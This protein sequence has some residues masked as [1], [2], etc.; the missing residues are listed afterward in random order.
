MPKRVMTKQDTK[1]YEHH[2]DPRKWAINSIFTRKVC[3]K[4]GTQTRVIVLDSE[5]G[6]TSKTLMNAGISGRNIFVP[7]INE[8]D[9]TMLRKI[10]VMARNVSIEKY[11]SGS[12]SRDCPAF[13]YDSMTTIS[14]NAAHGFY[15]GY[16]VDNYLQQ[17]KKSTGFGFRST[18]LVAVTVI[19]RNNQDIHEYLS[20]RDI[21]KSQMRAVFGRHGF[22][23]STRP[24]LLKYKNGCLFGMFE[25]CY[26]PICAK[27]VAPLPW[28]G[29]PIGFPAGSPMF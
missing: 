8:R 12:A 10:G 18:C 25:L 14:G 22:V 4:F 1:V 27:R 23:I 29:R 20:Q 13:W 11:V 9:C 15:I 28:K 7:N 19:D 17:F 2:M 3:R 21:F 16:A 24:R 6:V 26:D 5:Y